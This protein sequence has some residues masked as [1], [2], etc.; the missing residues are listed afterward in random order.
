MLFKLLSFNKIKKKI[1]G[2]GNQVTNIVAE[3]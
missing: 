3:K 2:T 1:K